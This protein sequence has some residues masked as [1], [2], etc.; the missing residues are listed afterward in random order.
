MQTP[1]GVIVEVGISLAMLN[2]GP[3]SQAPIIIISACF[4][5]KDTLWKT[6]ID[7]YH[8]SLIIEF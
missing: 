2:A 7:K 3:N 5:V 8:W 4:L 6:E 1:S